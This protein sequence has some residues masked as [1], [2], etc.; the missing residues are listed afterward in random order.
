MSR[1][2]IDA[3]LYDDEN[4]AEFAAH[5]LSVRQIDQILDNEYAVVENKKRRR[6]LYLVVGRDHGGRAITVPIHQTAQSGV[7]R[8][9]TA[10]PSK[11]GELAK[12]RP[13]WR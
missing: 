3:F 13:K 2:P 11:Q 12:L 9:V 7:W 6:G 5:G 1:P 8:P 4:E 10:W